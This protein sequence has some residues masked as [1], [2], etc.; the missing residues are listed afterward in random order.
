M[1]QLPNN[2]HLYQWEFIQSK[3]T[4]S[5]WNNVLCARILY[6]KSEYSKV[7][8]THTISQKVRKGHTHI[9]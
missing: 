7:H 1:E 8:S 4:I 2:I 3:I 6:G 9:I 5:G